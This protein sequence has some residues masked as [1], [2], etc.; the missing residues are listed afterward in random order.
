MGWDEAR[1]NRLNPQGLKLRFEKID[2]K[3]IHGKRFSRFRVFADGAPEG[4]AYLLGS[5]PVGKELSIDSHEIY[6]NEQ[7]LLMVHKPRPD[8]ETSMR[9]GEE[10]EL[11]VMPLTD[12]G[13]PM[14][15]ALSSLDKE[16]LIPGTVVPLP[17]VSQD[18]GCRLE[19]R[20][21]LP[22]ALGVLIFADGFPPKSRI[23][24]L[25][26]SEGE[27]IN[28]LLATD[29]NGHAVTLDFPRVVGKDNGLLRVTA[30]GKNCAP[31]VEFHWGAQP[32][33]P[34]RQSLAALSEYFR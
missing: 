3:P 26:V 8:Q 16:L 33:T 7:G 24:L 15:L 5:W 29:Q 2:E 13:E 12:E 23:P 11:D 20:T 30:Q 21:A 4:K 27:A 18:N 22:D 6:V 1:P 9:V 28:G 25:S 32:G 17:A 19:V 14:R 34:T 31:S 10:D